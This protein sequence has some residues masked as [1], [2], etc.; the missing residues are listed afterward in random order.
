[1]KKSL[2]LTAFVFAHLFVAAQS[3]TSYLY[4]NESWKSCRKDTAFYIAKIYQN[5]S[6]WERKDYWVKGNQVQ[7]EGAYLKKNC[8]TPQGLFKWYNE[9]GVLTTTKVY[10]SGNTMN[11]TIYYEDGSKRAMASY[12][13]GR[14]DEVKGWDE[15]GKE[16]PEYIFAREA[17]FPGGQLGW[18]AYLEQNLK[19]DVAANANAPLGT[20]TVKLQFIVTKEGEIANV[21][22]VE[23]PAR[24]F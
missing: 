14:Q 2:F 16:I 5:G 20:Y 18:R 22:A 15:S 19:A 10:E 11:I 24:C 12:K 8:K 17:R 7:M 13:D 9:K 21:K 1:M 23:V 4:F 6:V 3:D